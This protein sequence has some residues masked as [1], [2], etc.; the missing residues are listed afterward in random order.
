MSSM[1][2]LAGRLCQI[3]PA[4]ICIFMSSSIFALGAAVTSI[5]P[6]FVIFLF[7]RVI[8][9]IGAAGIFT[10]S[11][12]LVLQLTCK[13]RRGLFIG[14]V[15]SGYTIGVALGAIVAGALAPSIGWVC[16]CLPLYL[17]GGGESRSPV[18]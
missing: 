13:T 5:A 4:R 12:I 8:M 18:C 11:I 3:F 10:I 9:G 17:L 6:G 14:F 15:N 16:S 2:P 7:D 1:S